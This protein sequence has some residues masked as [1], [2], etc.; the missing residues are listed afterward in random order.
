MTGAAHPNGATEH[1]LAIPAETG[2]PPATILIV[3]PLFE[4]ANRL[5]RTLVLTMRA[6]GRL[7]LASVLPDLPGQNDSLI[8]TER[9]DLTQWRGA[10]AGVA[11]AIDGPIVVAAWRSGALIDDAAAAASGWWRMNPISGAAVVKTLVRVRIASAREAGRAISAE[12]VLAEA[13]SGPVELAGQRLSPGMLDDLQQA[14]P[15]PVAPLRDVTIGSATGQ[16]AGSALWLRA[17]PGE[18]TAMA[19]AMARDIADWAATCVAG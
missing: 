14:A 16:I 4:E 10:L 12:Q 5:R 9:V 13:L 7:G 11:A 15:N 19:A 1:W 17:E 3:P 8:A 6:L 18:D 2:L